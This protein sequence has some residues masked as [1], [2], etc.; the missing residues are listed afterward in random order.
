M[1]DDYPIF[2]EAYSANRGRAYFAGDFVDRPEGRLVGAIV[3]RY[4]ERMLFYEVETF[5]EFECRAN[6]LAVIFGDA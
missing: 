2:A 6:G 1:S 5:A 3:L 4:M